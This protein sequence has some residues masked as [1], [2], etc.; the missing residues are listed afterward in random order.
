MLWICRART[1]VLLL[2]WLKEINMQ[3]HPCVTSNVYMPFLVLLLLNLCSLA[4]ASALIV[5]SWLLGDPMLQCLVLPADTFFMCTLLYYRT[6]HCVAKHK[7]YS[8]TELLLLIWCSS[9]PLGVLNAKL[10]IKGEPLKVTLWFSGFLVFV[11][12]D[13]DHHFYYC[14]C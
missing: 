3:S 13:K 6:F 8:C 7:Q 1:F 14:V 12:K 2:F 5:H 11:S 9:G 4:V 10:M